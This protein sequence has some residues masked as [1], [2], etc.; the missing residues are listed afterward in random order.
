METEKKTEFDGLVANALASLN[1]LMQCEAVCRRDKAVLKLNRLKQYVMR[2]ASEV[3][4]EQ[5]EN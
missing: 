4:G 2:L 5:R 3:N 1:A